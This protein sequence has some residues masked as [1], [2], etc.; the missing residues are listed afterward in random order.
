MAH[1]VVRW[2]TKWCTE[3]AEKDR[4]TFRCPHAVAKTDCPF[5]IAACSDSNDGMVVKKAIAQDV[6]HY[7]N[8]HRDTRGWKEL[9]NER[10]AVER[11]NSR[12][13]EYLV[14]NDLH[15]RGIEKVTTAV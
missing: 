3:G 9:Y 5:G 2:A 12:L 1:S 11:C 15:V 10:T 4:L 8:P 13:K 6:R 14:V 7:A